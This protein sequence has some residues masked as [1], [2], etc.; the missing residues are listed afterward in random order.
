M[1]TFE[2][3]GALRPERLLAFELDDFRFEFGVDKDSGEVREL[4]ISFSV[5]A[6][7]VA[8]Y[9]D[10]SNDKIKAH[11]NLSQPR[12]ERVVE[13]VHHISGMWGI[14]G[15]Q[16][17]LVNEATTTFIPES[18]K[19]KLAI[20]VN[21]FKV[22]RARQP[23]L[24]DL[25]RLKPEYVVMPIIT[26]VKMK[27][28]DVRLSFYRRALQDVLNGEYIEAF[29]DYYFMLESTYGEGKTKN[30]HIQKKFLESELLS[31]TIEET[32]LSKQYKYSL[33]AELRSRYQVDYAGLTV[34][35]FI[36]K[37]VKLRGFLH[38]HNN[39]RCDGWKPTKQDDYRLEA[40]M[41]QD[42]CCRVGV[43]LFYESVEESNAKAV[44]QELVEK[45]IRNEEPTVSL[46]F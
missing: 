42:I 28:H 33:P 25:P 32:V 38:H 45:Y 23:F 15:L 34:S 37:I 5:H 21:N 3:V 24:G 14:W 6:N 46:K 30:T 22:K 43:E 17:V 4:M 16:D 29:Y 12:W 36:E 40:F 20:T 11:I 8:T 13:M 44:Y 39:K 18:D 27:N 31:S 19:D 2:L 26:A 1:Y 41:L 35:T 9:S 10:S 7:D